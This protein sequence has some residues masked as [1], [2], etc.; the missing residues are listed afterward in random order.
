M[1]DKKVLAG[2]VLFI[3][4]SKS[5][6]FIYHCQSMPESLRDDGDLVY[7]KGIRVASVTAPE[8]RYDQI[9]LRGSDSS[10]DNRVWI[11]VDSRLENNIQNMIDV[12]RSH[13]AKVNETMFPTILKEYL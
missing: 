11:Y 3:L 12:L 7:E 5:G 1:S 6:Q 9:Y 13:G 4:K 2:V 10:M 8:I